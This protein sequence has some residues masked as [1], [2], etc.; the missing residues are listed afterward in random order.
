MMKNT[1]IIESKRTAIGKFNGS[2]SNISAN[3]LATSVVKKILLKN[4]IYK[5]IIEE[6]IVGNALPA[7]LGQ[8]PARIISVKSGLPYNIPSFT[9][10]KVCGSGLKSIILAS[11]TIENNSA[12]CILAGGTENMSRCPYYLDNYRLGKKFG[13]TTIK[14]GMIYDGLF[15]SIVGEHMGITAENIAKKFK[16]SRYQQDKYAQNSHKKAT[17][18]IMLGKFD[19]EII[20]VGETKI[21]EQPRKDTNL[22][23]LA[24]LKTVFKKQGTVTAGNASSLNDGAAFSLVASESYIKKYKLCPMVKIIK[25]ASTGCQPAYMGLGSFYAAE[26]VLNNSGLKKSEIDLWEI[27]EAFAS[28]SLA[29]IKSLNIDS[30]KVNINGGAI[31]L[32]HPIGASGARILTTLIY[33]LKLNKLKYGIASLCIGGGQGIAILIEN[34]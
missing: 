31:A 15:C 3:D 32:G 9:I 29:V 28:Q 19:K 13:D 4:T 21:D 22:E 7:G 34:I 2:F 23:K 30:S 8:N 20:Q 33:A 6:V 24:I 26:K 25:Y 10:N 17:K 16:I 5:R 18:A 27:N 12:N 14:D 1:Y 11:Q